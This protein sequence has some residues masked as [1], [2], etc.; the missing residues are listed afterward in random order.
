M[1]KQE[2]F[3]RFLDDLEQPLIQMLLYRSFRKWATARDELIRYYSFETGIPEDEF[4]TAIAR[5]M[6]AAQG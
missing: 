1:T 3:D 6:S 5:K 2:I 4:H